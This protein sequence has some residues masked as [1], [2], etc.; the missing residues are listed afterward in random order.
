MESKGHSGEV[1]GGSEEHVIER[2][3]TSDPYY[4]VAEILTELST[5]VLWKVALVSKEIGYL[6]EV[7]SKQN[8]EGVAWFLLTAFS[9]IWEERDE[10]KKE[11]L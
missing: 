5:N 1:S 4:K 7:V 2:W 6:S 9:E 10:L 11:L 3:R 8:V